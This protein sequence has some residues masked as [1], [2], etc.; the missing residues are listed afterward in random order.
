MK[1]QQELEKLSQELQLTTQYLEIADRDNL[2]IKQ[3]LLKK[4]RDLLIAMEQKI[5]EIAKEEEHDLK[6]EAAY[7]I[8]I[9]E[10]DEDL[11]HIDFKSMNLKEFVE[12]LDQE[13]IPMTL[14]LGLMRPMKWQ[15]WDTTDKAVRKLFEE[16]KK[17]I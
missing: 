8:E 9:L 3:E 11:K 4:T 10:D 15:V 14:T 2:V 16:F 13:D 6:E 17:Q 7:I 5:E 1:K 12:L